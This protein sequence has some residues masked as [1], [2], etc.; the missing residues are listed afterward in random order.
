MTSFTPLADLTE[1]QL[2][3]QVVDLA[4]T[5]GFD[6]IYHTYDSRRSA[7]GFPDFVI[8]RERTIFLELK[9]ERGKPTPDQ[10][11]WLRGLLDAGS[12]AYLIRPRDLAALADVLAWRGDPLAPPATQLSDQSGQ[13]RAATKT[14][15][16]LRETTRAEAA[17]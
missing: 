10:R 3:T 4:R 6:L 11:R 9:A 1:A 7:H 5:L 12:E 16:R 14:A 13:R 17:A 2:T 15:E 8:A